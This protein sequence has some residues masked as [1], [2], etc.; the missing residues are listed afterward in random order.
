MKRLGCA[1]A[2]I[3]ALATLAPACDRVVDLTPLRDAQPL[4]APEFFDDG[5]V[6]FDDGGFVPDARLPDALAPPDALPPPDA[7]A[8]PDASGPVASPAHRRRRG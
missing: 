4:D 7:L 1:A 5:G 8:P 6:V 3:A 2:L